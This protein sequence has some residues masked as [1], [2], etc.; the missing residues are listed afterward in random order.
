MPSLEADLR[1]RLGKI[2]DTVTFLLGADLIDPRALKLRIHDRAQ[3]YAAQLDDSD[4]EMVAGTA[5]DL[6]RCGLIDLDNPADAASPLGILIG[7]TATDSVTQAS[8]TRILGYR[9]RSRVTRLLAAGL[10]TTSGPGR[11]PRVTRASVAE[12]LAAQNSRT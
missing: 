4:P 9:Y 1:E 10:L 3:Q 7:L 8:A 11:R 2:A 5:C 12:R 6:R